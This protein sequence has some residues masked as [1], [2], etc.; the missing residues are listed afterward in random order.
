MESSY[1]I[2][3]KNKFDLFLDE[4]ADPL[5]I[6]AMQEEA[7]KKKKEGGD[8]IKKDVKVKD[9]KSNKSKSKSNAPSSHQSEKPKITEDKENRRDT[10]G[11]NDIVV[12]EH[13]L[14][15][16]FQPVKSFLQTCQLW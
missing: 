11:M 14:T 6:L 4:E 16:L 13:V 9:T 7:K 12:D 5:E 8:K 1:G 3:V 15:N 10:S 2:A